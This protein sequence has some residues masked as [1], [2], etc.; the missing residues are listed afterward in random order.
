[1]SDHLNVLALL[2]P[3]QDPRTVVQ[4]WSHQ[5]G[6]EGRSNSKDPAEVIAARQERHGLLAALETFI[7]LDKQTGN[8]HGQGLRYLFALHVEGKSAETL[9]VR[10]NTTPEHIQNKVQETCAALRPALR[11]MMG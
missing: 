1:M 2:D 10:E 3:P 7:A 6:R 4:E 9:A 8:K 11:A 5:A